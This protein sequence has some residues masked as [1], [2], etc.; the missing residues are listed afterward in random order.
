MMED[1]AWMEI[2]RGMLGWVGWRFRGAFRRIVAHPIDQVLVLLP[3]E[4]GIEDRISLKFK[5]PVH[6]DGQ[7]G[8]HD[9]ARERVRHVRLE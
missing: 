1:V 9:A 4:S 6:L 3:T 5:E 7:R 8:L 2:G